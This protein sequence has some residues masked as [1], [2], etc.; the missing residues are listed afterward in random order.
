[1][2][3][4]Y[5]SIAFI[6]NHRLLWFQLAQQVHA[7]IAEKSQLMSNWQDLSAEH[8]RVCD[9]LEAV[10]LQSAD[11]ENQLQLSTDAGWF[12]ALVYRI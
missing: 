12:T 7:T 9:E 6:S 4:F 1:M 8:M 5:I 3:F 2:F 11:F 10:R